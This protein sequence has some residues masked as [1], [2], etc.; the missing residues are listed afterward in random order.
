MIGWTV[1][2][3]VGFALG[4]ATG[5]L[6]RRQKVLDCWLRDEVAGMRQDLNQARVEV[7]ALASPQASEMLDRVE[8][9][10]YEIS[11]NLDRMNTLLDQLHG[12]LRGK[13]VDRGEYRRINGIHEE[14]VIFSGQLDFTSPEEL[15]KF[16]NLPPISEDE[17]RA[18]D[19]ESFMKGI[20]S[21]G[22]AD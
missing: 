10:D 12:L 19:W 11:G 20:A 5:I 2:I 18:M 8:G 22:P 13:S 17:I 9:D 15:L 7:K 14:P 21:D 3:I 16:A 4:T 1:A 6:V